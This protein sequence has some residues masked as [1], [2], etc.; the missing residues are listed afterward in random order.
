M[1][2]GN[3]V[4][5]KIQYTEWEGDEERIQTSKDKRREGDI[6]GKTHQFYVVI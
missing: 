1:R 5:H 4:L 2:Y 6:M 3:F